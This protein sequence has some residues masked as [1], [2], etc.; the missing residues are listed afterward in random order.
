MKRWVLRGLIVLVVLVIAGVLAALY[1][2]G[3]IVKRGV[4]T[5]GPNITK[6]TVKLDGAT[7]SILSGN[8]ELKGF[9]V[10]NP[11]G[12]NTPSAVRV[13]S[14]AIGVQ[15]GSV[16][17]DKVVVRSVKVLG[18][19]I[20][21]EGTLTGNNLNKILANIRGTEEK[22]KQATSKQGQSSSKKMQ[23]DDFLITGG[24]INLSTSLLGG[25]STTL[26]L[27]EIH[28][29]NLGQGS[30][31]ITAAELAE[32]VFKAIVDET[33]KQVTEGSVGKNISDFTKKLPGSATQQLDKAT[34]GLKDLLKKK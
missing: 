6:T 29:T 18:P 22:D 14:V 4:E 27:P 9:L 30:D 8:G 2:L 5:A 16:F 11:E 1:F 32:R 33:V 21:F 10:G 19:E 17:S 20:T 3:A 7:L 23:V 15:P 31:G 13:G 12:F 28:L 34:G 25:Q 26:A 24:K